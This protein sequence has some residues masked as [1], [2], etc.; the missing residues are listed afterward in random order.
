MGSTP[1]SH[2]FVQRLRA[3]AERLSA[4]SRLISLHVSVFDQGLLALDLLD[5]LQA[6]AFHAALRVLER[7]RTASETAQQLDALLELEGW[8]QQVLS[9]DAP[10]QPASTL[11]AAKLV[12]EIIEHAGNTP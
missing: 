6:V 8:A 11:R 12:L 9:P 1:T 4:S 3:R 10:K 2:D 5:R 7:A